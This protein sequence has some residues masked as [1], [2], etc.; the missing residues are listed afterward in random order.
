MGEIYLGIV[1]AV[2]AALGYYFPRFSAYILDPAV[3]V[4]AATFFIKLHVLFFF[5]HSD[6]SAAGLFV[7]ILMW[8][9]LGF[10]CIVG[11][12]LISIGLKRMRAEDADIS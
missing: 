1:F 11:I 12:V 10:L 5:F 9:A 6:G 8:L 3:L 2:I 4:G 7:P